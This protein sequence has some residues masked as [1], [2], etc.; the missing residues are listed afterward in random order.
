MV[1]S[2]QAIDRRGRHIQ[3]NMEGGRFSVENYLKRKGFI[4]IDISVDIKGTFFALRY[5]SIKRKTLYEIFSYFSDLVSMGIDLKTALGLLAEATHDQ[6]GSYIL[7]KVKE[8]LMKG[9]RLSEAMR[10]SGG[11]P[12]LAVSMVT[13]GEES[14]SIN[15]T[16]VALN[17]YYKEEM[18]FV[19]SV[20]RSL[21]Y[22]SIIFIF[23][24]LIGLFIIYNIIPKLK[25]VFAVTH[26]L[27]GYTKTIMLFG[28]II[29][30]Y[31][32]IFPPLMILFLVAG[33]MVIK[34]N[35]FWFSEV[36]FR[37]PLIGKLF[38]FFYLKRIFFDLSMLMKNGTDIISS[39]SIMQDAMPDPSISRKLLK[40]RD[41]VKNGHSL[42]ESMQ[43]PFFPEIISHSIRKGEEV[44]DL[45]RY[46]ENL[47][48]YF[49]K[50]TQEYLK[51]IT[52]MI[53]PILLI[54]SAVIVLALALSFIIPVYGNITNFFI[55]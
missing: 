30:G 1:Y 35:P 5:R 4:P 8:L 53:E 16:F 45:P 34:T 50:R 38:K 20:K 33:Y 52:T 28:D 48:N 41:M 51:F 10:E 12:A 55:Q 19:S 37:V 13:I 46:L 23:A 21:I 15:D 6:Y 42:S 32:W 40:I 11:F 49:K 31:G 44:G 54:I 7:K 47:A 26:G 17:E 39:I 25:K 36:A 43:Q 24:S 2:Y 14:E 3:G 29:R 27:P 9:Y 18:E 22:P